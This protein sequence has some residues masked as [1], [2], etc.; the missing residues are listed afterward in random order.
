MDEQA[1]SASLN[2]FLETRIDLAPVS[3]GAIVQIQLPSPSTFSRA[4]RSQRRVVST[5]AACQDEESYARSCLATSSSIFFSQSQRY[6][7]SFLWRVL[8]DDKVLELRSIDVSKEDQEP[9]EAFVILQLTFPNAIRKR[10]VALTDSG[11]DSLCVFV[12]TKSKELFAL[13]IPTT[14]FCDVAVS[15]ESPERWCNTFTHSVINLSNPLGLIAASPQ[16]LVATLDDGGILRLNR[17][18]DR[19]TS[20]WEALTC[21]ESKWTASLRGLIRWQGSNSVRFNGVVLDSGSAIAA[22]F[23][24]A[25]THLLTVCLNHTLKIWNL[26]KGIVVFSMDLLGRD[27]EPQDVARVSLDAGNP[28]ILRVFEAKGAIEG[29]EYYAMTYSP[30]E[31]GQFKIW[32]IRDADQG[33]LGVRFLH[34]DNLFRP[35]DPEP[36]LENK[37]IWTLADLRI[38]QKAWGTAMQIWLLMRSSRRYKVYNLNF[39]LIDMPEA[40]SSDWTSSMPMSQSQH[41]P[42]PMSPS[43][44]RDVS[45]LWLEHLLYPGRYSHPLLE[46]ALST[47]CSSRKMQNNTTDNMDLRDRL[48]S[49]VSS[50]VHA[51]QLKKADGSGTEFSQY[52]EAMQDEWRLLYEQVQDL[53][54]SS[55]QALTLSFNVHSDM[56]WLLFTGGC[57]AI[58]AC[59]Q[60]ETVARNKA[61]LLQMYPQLFEAPSI[62]D[63]PRESPEPPY[64]L[65]ALVQAAA[66]FREAFNP[67][68]RQTCVAWLS[69]ELW[70]EPLLSV[71]KRIEGYYERC[72]FA[73]QITDSAIADLR[74]ALTPI[75]DFEGLK[76]AHFLAAIAKIPQVMRKH[77]SKLRL[78]RVGV[79]I[80]VSGAQ[81]MIDLHSRILFDLFVLVVFIEIEVDRDI[82]PKSNLDT[83][84]IFTALV[85]QLKHYRLMEWLAKSTWTGLERYANQLSDG[86]QHQNTRNRRFSVLETLF[87]ADVRPQ[88][89]Q[90]QSQ[91]EDLS[92][93]IQD[94]VVWITGGGDPSV[95]FE[96][97]PV[98]VMCNLLREN[99]LKLAADFIQ[100]QPS[101]PWSTY[102]KGRFYLASG[103]TTEA[104][105]CFQKAAYRM[106][107]KTSYDYHRAAAGFL[108]PAEAAHFGLGLPFYY[109]HIHQL[110]QSASY[111]LYAAQFAQL[112]LQFTPQSSSLEPPSALLTSLFHTSLQSFDTLT[113]FTA[114]MRLPQHDQNKLLPTML[115]VLM[116]LSDGPKQLLDLP[117][118][119]NIRPAIDMYLLNDK[120]PSVISSTDRPAIPAE[121]QRKILAAWRLKNGD[122]RGAAAALYPQLHTTKKQK[123]R[124]GPISKLR[125]GGS[126]ADECDD[127]A[128]READES[129][130]SVINLMACISGED[131][132]KGEMGSNHSKQG[133][134]WLLSEAGASKRRVVT[135]SDVR[136]G[137]QKELDRRS[138][139]ESGRWGF[140]LMDSDEMELG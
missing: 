97:I 123:Q 101:A 134:A 20:T 57:A 26:A 115:K 100:F 122:F 98:I 23:S 15:K 24:P 70:Q 35:P 78:S 43:D 46:A 91:S 71:P 3:E 33:S 19:G 17:K 110:F 41:V 111:P 54:R 106:A 87:A 4:P 5:A 109:H 50:P 88:P 140:G 120:S 89:F 74:E 108:S 51:Q 127:I 72:G 29:D 59:S 85:E 31:G 113:A 11:E 103:D 68:F 63:G 118:P 58:R 10:C 52:R 138:I 99:D 121:R 93:A 37:A 45:E 125:L 112:A 133:E 117:W 53:Q 131:E 2:S 48:L 61:A 9:N 137:W 77:D 44:I 73:E 25:R 105:L 8:G 36:S 95:P 86:P 42:P 75:G 135:I 18:S 129:Y 83:S 62:E 66:G 40:W 39:D 82:T 21:S 79:R 60:L 116:A 56:P 27:R 124:S 90:G 126:G 119:S 16:Q 1:P 96:E 64:R 69:N 22:E 107:S 34:P 81:E 32:A 136:R 132:S 55:W 114:L 104:A 28:N 13:N 128:C 14:F 65:A 38:G 130:L 139:V 94:L 92:N 67:S 76:T 80:L 12:L 6:P 30:H 7:R 84:L 102:L 49:A 47:Y